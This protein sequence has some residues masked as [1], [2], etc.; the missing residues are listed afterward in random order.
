MDGTKAAEDWLSPLRQHGLIPRG[1][2]AVFVVGS[3]ARGWHNP[4]SDFDV[5]VVTRTERV[6][7]S[8]GTVP[9]PLEPP[10]LSTELFYTQ[11][12][13]WDVT[14][15]LDSQI[16]QIFAK[17]SWEAFE[18]GR[19][20]EDTL[21]LREELLL[22]RLGSCLP[23]LGEA[24]LARCRSRLAESAFHSF[25]VVRSLGAA[26][27]AVED[28]LGQLEAGD[29][30]SATISARLAFGHV[31][32]ALLESH[33]EYGSHLPKWRPNR[34]R[35]VAPQA[36]SFADYWRVETMEGYDTAD[37]APWIEGVLTL[38]QDLAMRVET[39]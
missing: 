17:V 38:C 13:R 15:W 18:T 7:S 1:A 28:A 25:A 35:A 21:V 12:R 27:D 14:Y 22:G 19:V 32:N 2:L 37:P 16:D 11:S 29:L 39:S 10:R 20:T 5:Y 26:D 8:G 34:F 36:I 31:I 9:V 23:L 4:R 24:W 30:E 6:S 33:G 3:A